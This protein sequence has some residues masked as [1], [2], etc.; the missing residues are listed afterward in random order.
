MMSCSQGRQIAVQELTGYADHT[1]T[2]ST[3]GVLYKAYKI[4]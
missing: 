1:I 4:D 3:Q 2:R